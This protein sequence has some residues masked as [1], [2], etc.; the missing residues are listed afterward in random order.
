[1]SAIKSRAAL[2]V[3]VSSEEQVDGFSLDAQER[4]IADYRAALFKNP[5]PE[6]RKDIETALERLGA[7]P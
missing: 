1:M 5:A 3:R 4:A 2:Y 6:D 7:T